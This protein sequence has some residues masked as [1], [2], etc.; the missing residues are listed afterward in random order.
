[1]PE[2]RVRIEVPKALRLRVLWGSSPICDRVLS[3]PRDFTLGED[4]DFLF[5]ECVLGG[6]PLPWIR[7]RDGRI[8]VAVRSCGG[9]CLDGLTRDAHDSTL[10]WLE[11]RRGQSFSQSIGDFTLEARAEEPVSSPVRRFHVSTRGLGY[12]L[13]ATVVLASALALSRAVAAP[14]DARQPK[15][16]EDRLHFLRIGRSEHEAGSLPRGG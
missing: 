8:D 12:F 2:R 16:E 1:M 14:H 13:G 9:A 3:P 7:L 4:G 15:L 5:P 11:L 6:R 10:A